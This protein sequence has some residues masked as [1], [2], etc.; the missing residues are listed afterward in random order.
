[1]RS[2]GNPIAGLLLA[3]LVAAP[4]G[5]ATYKFDPGHTEV[6]AVW[7]HAGVSE[8]SARW[9]KVDGT[10][11]F[12]PDNVGATTVSVTIDAASVNSGVQKLD[13]HLQSADFFEVE[14]YPEI[15]F[16]STEVIKTGPESVRVIGDLTIKETTRPMAF[17]VELVHRGDH[18][19]G[20]FMDRFKGEWLGIRASGELLRSEFGVG[21][22]APMVSDLIRLEIST[23]MQRADEES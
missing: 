2:L 8:Q 15:T 6:R 20:Q 17:D 21:F 7:D 1:M 5:A 22:G 16:E 13:Q 10:I 23:E 9:G 18:P 3:G 12:D 19:L 14:T 11:D 4:A